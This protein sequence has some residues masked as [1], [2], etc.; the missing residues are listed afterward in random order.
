MIVS[1]DKRKKI[2]ILIII[3]A[4]IVASQWWCIRLV[5]AKK[6]NGAPALMLAKIY[7]LSAGS[8]EN[9]EKNINVSLVDYLGNYSFTNDFI[10]KQGLASGESIDISDQQIKDEVWS[11]VL[12]ESWLAD[13]AK[14]NK[15]ILNDQDTEDF[16]TSLGGKDNRKESLKKVGINIGQYE[17][18]VVKPAIIE[19]KIYKFLLDNFNDLAGM[20]KAQNAYKALVDDKGVFEEVAKEYSDDMSYVNDSM[21]INVDQLGDFGEPIKNLQAG[22]YSKI[23]VLP[24]NPSYYIIWRLQ[25]TSVDPETKQEV[26]ELRGVAIKAKSMDEFFTDWKNSSKINQKYK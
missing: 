15:I 23:V 4:L 20:Q 19:A 2:L 25:G 26:K 16:Y 12:R 10:K 22:E 8:I 13:L 17:K 21:F 7:R 24:G 1:S 11:K 5:Y 14:N 18:F 3:V 6:I 9:S